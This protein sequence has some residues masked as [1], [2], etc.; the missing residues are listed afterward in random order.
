M[1][2]AHLSLRIAPSAVQHWSIIGNNDNRHGDW[3]A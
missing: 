1:E 2:E 3:R